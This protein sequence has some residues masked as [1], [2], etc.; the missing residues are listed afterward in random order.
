MVAFVA[1]PLGMALL[2]GLFALGVSFTIEDT[3]LSHVLEDEARMQRAHAEQHGTWAVP[4]IAAITLHADRT[5][6][7]SNLAA[8][9]ADAEPHKREVTGEGGRV[10]YVLGIAE[11][12]GPPWLVAEARRDLVVRPMR[13]LLLGWLVAGGVATAALMLTLAWWLARDLSRPLE[14]LA[15]RVADAA[16]EQL[17]EHLARGMRDDEV[18]AVAR[19]F[20]D[21]LARTRA[22]IAREQAFTR[23]ASHEL[24]TPLAVL[25]MAID[26]LQAD[27]DTSA[28][29]R[30][31]LVP[32]R[33]ATELMEQTITTLLLLAREG[34]ARASTPVAVLPLVERWVV[35]HADWLD[36]QGLT[37]E[38]CLQRDDRLHLPEPVL[39]LAIAGLLGNAFAHGRPGGQVR[40]TCEAGALCICNPGAALPQGVGDAFVKGASS[41]GSGL[42]LSIVRRLLERHGG[43]LQIDHLDGQTCA[44]VQGPAPGPGS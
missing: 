30:R 5:T 26:R 13:D 16:P 43:Q 12:G 31:Q 23:D 40:V 41:T 33:E 7:P 24:R 25:G 15:Q 22:F 37:L 9:L 17:P 44:R 8:L 28:S 6:L 20:D 21:V 34:P 32:M 42:G 18:G 4:R 38:L 3:F 11:R 35:A 39:Q 29:V 14:D 36:R 19:R 10:Y 1:I 27:P 2:F